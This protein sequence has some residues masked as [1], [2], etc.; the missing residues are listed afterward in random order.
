MFR[1]TYFFRFQENWHVVGC[2]RALR[3]PAS[4]P[5]I[6]S[7]EEILQLLLKPDTD[8]DLEPLHGEDNCSK[9]ILLSM[10][11]PFYFHDNREYKSFVSTAIIYFI[12]G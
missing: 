7:Y 11:F 8:D 2:V 5:R 9:Y 6:L 10:S 1:G 12:N 4:I 3:C